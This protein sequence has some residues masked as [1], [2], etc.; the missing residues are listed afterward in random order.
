MGKFSNALLISLSPTLAIVP[1]S[2]TPEKSVGLL[3][4]MPTPA[5]GKV[6]PKKAGLACLPNGS[7]SA[8]DFVRVADEF[9]TP[10][11]DLLANR[12]YKVT[13]EAAKSSPVSVS[14]Q[15]IGIDASICAPSWGLGD[16]SSVK[17]HVRFLFHWTV[18][19][20]GMSLVETDQSVLVD[21]KTVGRKLQTTEFLAQIIVP[22][23]DQ[24]ENLVG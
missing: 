1:A 6:G 8:V 5:L 7:V 9:A 19:R 24:F 13:R 12:G 4:L 15:L 3:A 10:L 18:R 21:T 2:A 16:K 22:L 11:A 23:A 14:V 20:D 17:G